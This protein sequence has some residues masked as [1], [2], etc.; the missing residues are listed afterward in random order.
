MR[1]DP[2]KANGHRRRQVTARV[3]AEED[4]CAL[5]GL[6]VDKALPTLDP[7]TGGPHPMAKSIDE[8]VPVSRGGSPHDRSNCHLMHRKCN[9]W[10][11]DR[12]LAEARAAW[13]ADSERNQRATAVI[14]STFW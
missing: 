7:Q 10:K 1:T 11:S 3:Y 8:D 4:V 14:A 6:L 9:R 12:T 13:Q 2:R 5:C